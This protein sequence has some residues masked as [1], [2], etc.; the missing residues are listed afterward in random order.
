MLRRFFSQAAKSGPKKITNRDALRMGMSEEMRRDDRIF[1]MGEEVGSFHGSYKVSKG[2]L[3]EFGPSRIIDTPITEAG[4]TGLGAGASYLGLIPVIE[5]MTWNFALQSIDHIVNS[6]AK[7]RY[8]SGG[9]VSGAIV[10]RGVNG[11]AAS[12]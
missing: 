7:T 8:M 3:A 5:F 9:D 10:F 11:P 2:M 1:L 12:V 6:C 4:F